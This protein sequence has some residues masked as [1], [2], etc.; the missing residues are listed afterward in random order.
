M[1]PLVVAATYPGE[2]TLAGYGPSSIRG[3]LAD[4]HGAST[5]LPL[6]F[7]FVSGLANWMVL[8]PITT[9]VLRER[10]RQGGSIIAEFLN[11]LVKTDAFYRNH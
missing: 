1:L 5:L 6:A 10:R 4:G 2:Q 8:L 9:K 11:L 3:V 7:T